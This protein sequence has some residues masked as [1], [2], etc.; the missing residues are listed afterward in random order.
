MTMRR[1]AWNTGIAIII[2]LFVS[3]ATATA[4]ISPEYYLGPGYTELPT[5]CY[6]PYY[7]FNQT[8]P[9]YCSCIFCWENGTYVCPPSF[10]TNS[11]NLNMGLLDVNFTSDVT[12]GLAPLEVRFTDLSNGNPNAWL[13]EFGDG[14]TSSEKNPVHTYTAPGH[15]S[16]S[17][18]VSLNYAAD[19]IYISQSRGIEKPDYI[20]VTGITPGYQGGGSS[21]V[22]GQSVPGP[23]DR[24]REHS[25][26]EDLIS[27]LKPTDTPGFTYPTSSGYPYP[28]S[29]PGFPYPTGTSEFPYP[30]GPSPTSNLLEEAIG[31]IDSDPISSHELFGIEGAFGYEVEEPDHPSITAQII[32]EFLQEN[33][34][35]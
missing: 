18:T 28:P 16:V 35:L 3:S 26:Y 6:C 1:A 13:W 17:L 32:E 2:F 27:G 33:S 21:A 19:G 22:P 8:L 20:H 10:G 4:D 25:Q 11:H 5:Y 7:P 15:Y 24:L 31:M 12:S 29:T 14:A 9:A 23:I 34:R 30:T